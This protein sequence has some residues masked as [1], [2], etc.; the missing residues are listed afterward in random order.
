M[1]HTINM[2]KKGVDWRLKPYANQKYFLNFQKQNWSCLDMSHNLRRNQQK[3]NIK[4]IPELTRICMTFCTFSLTKATVFNLLF[5]H[6]DNEK[7]EVTLF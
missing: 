7:E 5:H 2:R 3:S 4:N 6:L 1:F